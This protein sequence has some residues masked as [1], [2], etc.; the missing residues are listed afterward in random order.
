MKKKIIYSLYKYI[1]KN[2]LKPVFTREKF[3]DYPYEIG[4]FTYGVPSIL[5]WGENT[6]L[7]IGKFCS[8]STNVK[9]FLGGEHNT[10]WI[11]TFPFNKIFSQAK[12]IPGHPKSKGNVYIGNDV[13]IGEGVTILSGIT[14]GDGAIIGARSVVTK[15]VQPYAIV[16]GNPAKFIRLRFSESEAVELL[17]IQWWNWPINK[18]TDELNLIMSSNIDE[19]IKKHHV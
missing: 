19:F 15:N 4:E 5:A 12:D 16:A 2:K 7:K 17:R 14:I 9:I 10:N 13:W 8:I 6:T 11:S 18:I 3:K 1:F